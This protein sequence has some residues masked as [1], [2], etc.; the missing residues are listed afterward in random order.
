ME[1]CHMYLFIY[2]QVLCFNSKDIT[3]QLDHALF[4]SS[5]YFVMQ[6]N[7]QLHIA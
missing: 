2:C 3:L 7:S 6:M 1:I 5:Y 4:R